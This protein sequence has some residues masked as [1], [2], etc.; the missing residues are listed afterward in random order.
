MQN[1]AIYTLD[2]SLRAPYMA[3]AN[4]E[5]DRQLPGRTQVSLNIVDTRGVHQLR[6][7]DINAPLP[8]TYIGPPQ[9]ATFR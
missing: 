1:Q 5:I 3:Q 6:E 7:R 9:E 2:K 8:G 4:L